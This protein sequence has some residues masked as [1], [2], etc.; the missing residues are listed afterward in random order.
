MR[1]SAFGFSPTNPGASRSR[2]EEFSGP[3]LAAQV[4]AIS[5]EHDGATEI[6]SAMGVNGERGGKVVKF[7]PDV[8]DC[9]EPVLTALCN[10]LID[11]EIIFRRLSRA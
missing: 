1:I 11:A 8:S 9:V 10:L 7:G 3:D 5:G 2:T 4:S 6:Q